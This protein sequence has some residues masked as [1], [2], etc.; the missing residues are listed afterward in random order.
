VIVTAK[1]LYVNSDRYV[2]K[3]SMTATPETERTLCVLYPSPALTLTTEFQKVASRLFAKVLTYERT[4]AELDR[5]PIPMERLSTQ[6]SV[7]ALV[8]TGP[9]L[10]EV[11]IVSAPVFLIQ[12]QNVF[13]LVKVRIALARA[14]VCLVRSTQIQTL[15]RLEKSVILCKEPMNQKNVIVQQ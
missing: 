11:D 7:L 3:V 13:V 10:E 1:T 6:Q 9:A 15:T 5:V 14:C 8:W 2:R 12:M 4:I